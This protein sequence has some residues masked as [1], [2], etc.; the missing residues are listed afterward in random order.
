MATY[1][2]ETKYLFLMLMEAIQESLGIKVEVKKQ[3]EE[4][5]GNDNNIL[6][7]LEDGSQMM[8]V[9][10]YPPCPEPDL[11]LGM[12]PHS[13]YG[14]LTLLLQDQV[15][16]LQIQF[17]GQWFTVQPINNAFVVNVG[18]HLEVVFKFIHSFITHSCTTLFFFYYYYYYY[19]YYY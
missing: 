16:G 18:D 14:F 11:T 8:V 15:E 17:Q 4:T 2:E 1:S 19:Y 7:D 9:N 3:E 10:F 6:K 5:E 12:P 13:D